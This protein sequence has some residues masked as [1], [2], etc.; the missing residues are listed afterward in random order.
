MYMVGL[1]CLKV[2]NFLHWSSCYERIV[3]WTVIERSTNDTRRPIVPDSKE[4]MK[5][6]VTSFITGVH[7]F[8]EIKGRGQDQ[9]HLPRQQTV[10]QDYPK[11]VV[12]NPIIDR[13]PLSFTFTRRIFLHFQ[14]EG[15]PVSL[16]LFMRVNINPFFFSKDKSETLNNEKE[17]RTNV[18]TQTPQTHTPPS[19]TALS[20][21]FLYKSISGDVSNVPLTLWR[22]VEPSLLWNSP[23]KDFPTSK[24][25]W[26]DYFRD[27]PIRTNLLSLE[28]V[29]TTP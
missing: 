10:L 26:Q 25:N 1:F 28:P 2:K 11:S 5:S 12:L 13:C 14:T 17:T 18:H 7:F 29:T 8:F 6:R 27:T 20:L 21:H 23:G 16:N 22:R 3:W 19:H 15:T 24:G 9:P 4:K